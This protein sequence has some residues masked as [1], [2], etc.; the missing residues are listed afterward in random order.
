MRAG[1]GDTRPGRRDSKEEFKIP[2]FQFPRLSSHLSNAPFLFGRRDRSDEE[3]RA[4]ERLPEARN[5]VPGLGL[6]DGQKIT[7]CSIWLLST[8]ILWPGSHFQFP[9]F[10]RP[11][12]SID[13]HFQ[14]DRHLISAFFFFSGKMALGSS[15]Q[16][17]STRNTAKW[18]SS[19]VAKRGSPL[20]SI[21]LDG[22]GISPRATLVL[23]HRSGH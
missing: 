6:L 14:I 12:I 13:F 8:F 16:L 21:R 1:K 17:E 23:W 20:P 15:I 19:P 9:I 2:L 11:P 22:I 4:E 5:R 7:V 10:P 3:D 18:S